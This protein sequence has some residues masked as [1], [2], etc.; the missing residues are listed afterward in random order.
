MITILVADDQPIMRRGVKQILAEEEE[1]V[2]TD[3]TGDRQEGS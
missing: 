1:M 2:V 3:E